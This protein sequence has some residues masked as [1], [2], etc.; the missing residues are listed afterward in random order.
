MEE[1]IGAFSAFLEVQTALIAEFYGVI[2]AVEET[3]KMGLTNVWL[4]CDSALVYATFTDRTNVLW[5]LQNRWITCL[6][7][8][9]KIRF[10]VIM[11]VVISWLIMDLFIENHFI[12]IIGFHII[13]S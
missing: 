6:N 4:K 13:Y 3:Q 2:Y 5:M 10:R 7:Y 11:H 9:G 12:G 8:C 1:F